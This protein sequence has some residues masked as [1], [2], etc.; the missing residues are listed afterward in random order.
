MPTR[1][2]DFPIGF[3]L[4]GGAWQRDIGA[5]AQWAKENGFEGIDLGGITA[6]NAQALAGAGLKLGTV[7]LDTSG[8]LDADAGKRKEAVAR[9]VASVQAA[10][11]LGAKYFFLVVRPD[12][13]MKRSEAH[14]LAVESFSP[15]AGALETQNA[16]L[17][18]E[19]W[20]GGSP[21]LPS[22][23][24]TPES[25]RRFFADIGGKGVGL[26]YDP[27]HLIRMGIDHV[28]FLKEFL[29]YV[30]H[31]HGKDTELLSEAVYEYGLYQPAVF[32]KPHGWG[33]HVWRYTI[34]G[35]GCARWTEILHL[36][37]VNGFEGMVSIE[38]E[39]ENFNG[40]EAGEKAG[41]LHSLRFLQSV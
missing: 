16:S 39:D 14:D 28:R 19:G 27:S 15:I 7:D 26:N 35:H 30:R 2:G 3:R 6:E 33:E 13:A 17:A 31:V 40:S 36:L 38:L 8:L 24:C 34:P 4:G 22:L 32:E 20:P 10:T 23:C 37:K 9:S 29:P 1:T 5:L 12:P 11:A 21:H 41:L 25:C 18:I